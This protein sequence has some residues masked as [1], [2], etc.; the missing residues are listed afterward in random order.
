M[1]FNYEQ[2]FDLMAAYHDLGERENK[3]IKYLMTMV[4]FDGGYKEL[5]DATNIEVSNLRN[6]LLY[7]DALGIVNIVRCKYE[8]EVKRTLRK[9]GKIASF[10]K[11]KSCYLVDGWMETL[12][13]QYKKGLIHN[14]VSK[15]KNVIEQM[16]L[17]EE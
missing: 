11:M 1:E 2:T 10:N 8:D 6:C 9:D 7:L 3:I 17:L 16:K 13:R 14:N 5:A 12:I 4:M 15:K